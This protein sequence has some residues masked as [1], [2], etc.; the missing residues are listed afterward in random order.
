MLAQRGC[1]RSLP[2]TPPYSHTFSRGPHQIAFAPRW[3]G[4]L[5]VGEGQVGGWV[6]GW[7]VWRSPIGS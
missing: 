5:L 7:L 3:G 4:C 2:H 1:L 6:A